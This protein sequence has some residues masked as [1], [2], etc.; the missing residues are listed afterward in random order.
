MRF[1]CSLVLD[2][3]RHTGWTRQV[4]LELA[5]HLVIVQVDH[6][7]VGPAVILEDSREH[8]NMQ[9]RWALHTATPLPWSHQL[10]QTTQTVCLCWHHLGGQWHTQHHHAVS[11]PLDLPGKEG[12]LVSQS[13][14]PLKDCI[15]LKL[16]VV[17]FNW[18]LYGPSISML[19]VVIVNQ[20]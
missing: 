7:G 4:Y 17:I 19:P 11:F 5:S 14:T 2:K 16:L 18:F 10:S 13:Q 6:R 3:C 20:I 15:P 8:V 12:G 1:I 9:I